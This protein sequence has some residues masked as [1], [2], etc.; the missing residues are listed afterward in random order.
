MT[1]WEDLKEDTGRDG[2]K[3]VKYSVLGTEK[4]TERIAKITV[5]LS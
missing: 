5:E 2:F 1:K 4:Y 3:N